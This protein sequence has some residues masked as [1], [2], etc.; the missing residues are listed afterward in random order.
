MPYDSLVESISFSLDFGENYL[1]IRYLRVL[2]IHSPYR[3][4]MNVSFG[5]NSSEK[6]R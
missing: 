1:F 2:T 4:E 5:L 3:V 6:R